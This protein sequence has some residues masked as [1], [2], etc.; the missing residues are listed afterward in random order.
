MKTFEGNLVAEN[1][2]IGIVV[3]RFNEFHHLRLLA[4][5]WTV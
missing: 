1:I 5:P 4:G 3:S 2:R